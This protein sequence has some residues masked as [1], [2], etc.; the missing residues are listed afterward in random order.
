MSGDPPLRLLQLTDSHLRADRRGTLK[1]WRTLDSL[2]L[3][4]HKA[5]EDRQAPDAIL[6]TGDLSQD[7]SR[8]SYRHFREVVGGVGVP[9]FCIPGN[10]DDPDAMAAELSSAPFHYCANPAFGAWRLVMLSTWDGDRGGGRL[11]DEE[12]G[13]LG[14][15]LD[16]FTEPHLLVVLHHHPVPVGSWLD[17]V[18]LDNA[19][20][21]LAVTDE[22]PRVRGIVW[23]HVHQAH[24]ARRNGVRLLGTPSTCFQF[25]PHVAQS[26]LDPAGGPGWRWL[27]LGADGQ[28]DSSVG[29][30]PKPAGFGA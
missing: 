29:H 23:G 20:E 6:A 28:I 11:T 13:R 27:E 7:G 21:F 30:A 5:L 14:R 25:L 2:E 18:A 24:D 26:E 9:V 12:L 8:E 4:L 19:A 10:H 17:Q 1:G 16:E 22:C 3:A 15:A